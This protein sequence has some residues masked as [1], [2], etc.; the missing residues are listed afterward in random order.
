LIDKMIESFEATCYELSDEIK[1]K[2][3]ASDPDSA[4]GKIMELYACR[5]AGRA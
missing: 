2:L 5:L 1:A 3:L 4:R